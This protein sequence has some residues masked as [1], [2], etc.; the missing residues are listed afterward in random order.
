MCWWPG[1]AARPRRPRRPRLAGVA[2]VLVA[3]APRS[4]HALAEPMAALLVSLAP[5]YSH[6]L[7]AATRRGQERDAAR[8]GPARRAADHR[9]R[10]RSIGPDTFVRPIY[11]GNALATVKSADVRPRCMTVR[12]ASFD[13]VPAEGGSAADRGGARG[14]HARPW[15]LRL[16]RTV[17]ERA[18]R[19]D[20]RARG[21]LGRARHAE[22]REF[23]AAGRRSPT[24][25]ARRSAPAAPRSMPAS[26]P[27]IT[28]SARPARSSPPSS[29]SPSAFP[30][31]FSTSPA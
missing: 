26:S 10:R 29:M 9:D 23:Q 25:S 24:S 7:A 30:A 14:R 1:M 3:D 19:A 8:R 20:R 28:R 15:P 13:P 11:A 17:G 22:R 18:P 2:K 4:T 27:T 12:A 21:R 6:L 16:G 5:A 31:P